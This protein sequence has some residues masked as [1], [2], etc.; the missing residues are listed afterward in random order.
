MKW[1]AKLN[2]SNRTC[3]A[4]VK[5]PNWF[6]SS[7]VL[8][9]VLIRAR[10]LNLNASL[11][12]NGT[13]CY[14]TSAAQCVCP[15][16]HPCECVWWHPANAAVAACIV[17]VRVFRIRLCSAAAMWR[18]WQLVNSPTMMTRYLFIPKKSSSE[19]GLRSKILALI[20]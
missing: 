10:V 8:L 4:A 11:G 12:L 13:N 19:Y 9:G 5:E 14:D 15:W 2:K 20:C 7:V 17:W 6:R 16:R 18:C 1:F 3:S